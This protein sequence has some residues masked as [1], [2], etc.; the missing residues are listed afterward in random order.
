[1]STLQTRR[2]V[3]NYS[4]YASASADAYSRALS[5]M[6]CELKK[7]PK[8]IDFETVQKIVTWLGNW[9][10]EDL[11]TRIE[12]VKDGYILPGNSADAL[13]SK[14]DWQQF[15]AE[16]LFDDMRWDSEKVDFSQMKFYR[17]DPNQITEE[18]IKA[19]RSLRDPSDPMYLL[20]ARSLN[21]LRVKAG[22]PEVEAASV[23]SVPA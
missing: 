13:R 23:N 10:E 21:M 18:E 22:L 4:G 17:C 6:L 9:K 14:R 3:I 20:D 12:D 7:D 15:V 2:A 8:G 16:V 5:Y 11:S 1:M 19:G